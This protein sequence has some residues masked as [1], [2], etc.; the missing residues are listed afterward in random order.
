M[1]LMLLGTSTVV[2]HSISKNQILL[3]SIIINAIICS[4]VVVLLLRL[5]CL[6]VNP[7]FK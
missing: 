4:S 1:L 5:R 7:F 3:N 6:N 2:K